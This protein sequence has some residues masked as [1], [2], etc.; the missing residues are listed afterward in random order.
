MRESGLPF[1]IMDGTVMVWLAATDPRD[2]VK[3]IN[4]EQGG[5]WLLLI[6]IIDQIMFGFIG[7]LVPKFICLRKASF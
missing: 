5:Y 4:S 7:N 3:S 1:Y 6:I 2:V